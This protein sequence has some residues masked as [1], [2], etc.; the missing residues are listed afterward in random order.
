M[1]SK[2]PENHETATD[3]KV[4]YRFSRKVSAQKA[5]HLFQEAKAKGLPSGSVIEVD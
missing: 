4:E 1:R 5:F 3:G 2:H